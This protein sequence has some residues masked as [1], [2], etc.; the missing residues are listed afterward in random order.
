MTGGGV[1]RGPGTFQ[2]PMRNPVTK[3]F[4]YLGAGEPMPTQAEMAA[5]VA[6]AKARKAAAQQPRQQPVTASPA[7][8]PAAAP[9]KP[10]TATTRQRSGPATFKEALGAGLDPV[11]F[12]KLI[13]N[14][15]PFLVP[16]T[17]EQARW[18]CG[19]DCAEIARCLQLGIIRQR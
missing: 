17:V 8:R 10:R 1:I 3:E 18:H 7:S 11:A 2:R 9:S 4:I 12:F 19:L 13:E 15:P 14:D 6:V 5:A 16:S